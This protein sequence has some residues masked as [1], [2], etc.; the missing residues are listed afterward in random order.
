[1]P[2]YGFIAAAEQV[3]FFMEHGYVVIK[4]A[5]TRAQAADFTK[6]MWIRLGMDPDDKATWTQERIHMPVTK[7]VRVSEFAPK[8]RRTPALRAICGTHC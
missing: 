2:G 3:D 7:R 4:Q 6:E 5:F 8:V 1:M